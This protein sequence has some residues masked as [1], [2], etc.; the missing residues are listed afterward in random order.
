M[1][2]EQ[3]VQGLGSTRQLDEVAFQCFR[4]AVEEAPDVARLKGLVTRLAP[5]LEHARDQ[6]IRANP[7]S[8][9][10]DHEI[11]CGAVLDFGELVDREAGA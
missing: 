3:A 1:G 11:V 6:L 4:E 8:A 5:F 10:A 7:D 9:G 2:I